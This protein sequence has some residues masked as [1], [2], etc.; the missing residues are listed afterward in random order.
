MSL[1][2]EIWR[3]LSTVSTT[4]ERQKT[5]VFCLQ[6][7]AAEAALSIIGCCLNAAGGQTA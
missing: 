5:G 2:H 6:Q 7:V 4:G 3:R 1:E